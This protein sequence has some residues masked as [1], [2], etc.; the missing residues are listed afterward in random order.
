MGGVF[1]NYRTGDGDWAATL[2]ARELTTR[3][4]ADSVFFA[5]RSIRPGQDFAVQILDRIPHCD[6]LLVVVGGQWFR[7]QRIDDPEDWVHREIAIALR[8]GVLVVPVLLDG[9]PR[10]T[11][12]DLPTPLAAL[13]RCQY[14]RLHHRNDDRDVARLLDELSVLLPG[15]TPVGPPESVPYR[16]LL[17]FRED[18]APVFHGRDREVERLVRLV[19]QQPVVV[20]AGAS[21][22]GKS[23]LVR[24]GLLPALREQNATVV[25]FRPIRDVNPGQLLVTALKSA[26]G[27]SWSD[28]LVPAE[29]PQLVD[30]IVAAVGELVLCVDQ[31]EEAVAADP[32]AAKELF[33]AIAEL[34]H[35]APSRPGRPPAVRA[36]FTCRST[37]LDDVQVLEDATVYVRQLGRDELRAAILEPART[38]GVTFEPG[39]VDRVLADALDAPG[40]LPLVEFTLT[41]LWETQVDEVLTHRAYAE[42][43]G[44]GGALATWAE[45]VYSSR[46]S[47]AQRSLVKQL[48]V[49][50]ARPAPDGTFLS[51]PAR[52]SDLSAELQILAAELSRQRLV[53]IRQDV[54]QPEVVALAHEALVRA[55]TRLRDWLTAAREFRAWQEQLR[56]NLD[57]WQRS[58]RDPDSLLRG[59]LLAAAEQWRTRQ[60][61]TPTERHY[62]DASRARQRQT[63]RRWR[64]ITVAAVAVA[65]FSGALVVIVVQ[66]GDELDDRLH[67]ATASTLAQQSQRA[68]GEEPGTA[69]QLAQAAWREKPGNKDAFGALLQQFQAWQHVDHMLPPG[70]AKLHA[71]ISASADGQTIATVANEGPG[72]IM[73]RTHAQD[74][75]PTTW[76]LRPSA[77]GP[78][79]VSPDGQ[80]LATS[81]GKVVSLWNIADH[82]GPVPL[83]TASNKG[84]VVDLEL[85]AGHRYLVATVAPDEDAPATEATNRLLMWDTD[86]GQ[87]LP[88]EISTYGDANLWGRT[89]M[90]DGTALLTEERAPGTH[91]PVT[92]LRDRVTGRPV[93]S[94]TYGLILANGAAVGTCESGTLHVRSTATGADLPQVTL[95]PCD[96]QEYRGPDVTGQFLLL[97]NDVTDAPA[98]VRSTFLHWQS[99][100]RYT[101]RVPTG[102]D[103]TESAAP[104]VAAADP[105]GGVSMLVMFHGTFARIR[106]SEPDAVPTTE[107]SFVETRDLSPSGELFL[108]DTPE[109]LELVE[110]AT[111][112][113]RGRAPAAGSQNTNWMFTSDEQHVL[114]LTEGKAAV[115]HVPDLQLERTIDVSTDASHGGFVDAAPLDGSRV[116]IVHQGAITQWDAATGRPTAEPLRLSDNP[117][118]LRGFAEYTEIR[119][120]PHHPGQLVLHTASPAAAIQVW[121]VFERRRTASLPI[122]WW[123]MTRSVSLATDATGTHLAAARDTGGVTVWNLDEAL[124]ESSF[125]GPD[126][127][128]YGFAGPYLLTEKDNSLQVWDWRRAELLADVHTGDAASRY[129]FLRGDT[130]VYSTPGEHMRFIPMDPNVWFRRL[131][132]INNRDFTGTEKVQLPTA[133]SR[134]RPCAPTQPR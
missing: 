84:I 58:D 115:Y 9:A 54:D 34:V 66:R 74:L 44:V 50:L 20:V 71:G 21:G 51:A 59:S 8:L 96:E 10:L 14:V 18:D 13:A 45:E 134:D 12:A 31:F 27:P 79:A 113:V 87:A 33:R 93:R 2:I 114:N 26:L 25:V 94:F 104:V 6:V 36:V 4:G 5:S 108:Q 81:D 77:L 37:D 119:P 83:R 110:T 95:A 105:G 72:S 40:Q 17:P 82:T 89:P 90:P 86:S 128:I 11:E 106:L 41:R 118:E 63:V 116:A 16:G 46:L 64:V 70:E 126:T 121:D 98:A 23:S 65:L 125:G 39:L 123:D 35:A 109:A 92:Y 130:L 97:K 62:I 76:R 38:L 88:T 3:F 7:D 132:E 19:A 78:F 68:S 124:P 48:L 99:G 133:A 112:R 57:Q 30:P 73:V 122:L 127:T 111:G 117:E 29:L 32:A 107:E 28:R 24:A 75:A 56:V 120:R 52:L 49:Q 60:S 129:S 43:D 15:E 101:V 85:G 22:S 55:W 80:L 1:V 69:I 91:V 103:L 131:C 53:V 42:M 67:D 102:F 61:L 47:A 100:R